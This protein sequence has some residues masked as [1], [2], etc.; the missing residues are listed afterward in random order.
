MQVKQFSGEVFSYHD[1]GIGEKK[2]IFFF[3]EIAR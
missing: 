3:S 2:T 1:D